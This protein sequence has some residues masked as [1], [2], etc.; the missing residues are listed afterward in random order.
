MAVSGF[1]VACQV[2]QLICRQ[3]VGICGKITSIKRS[4]HIRP[5]VWLTWVQQ[6]WLFNSYFTIAAHSNETST[7]AICMQN[8]S[9][10]AQSTS[11][12]MHNIALLS[13]RISFCKKE[14]Q[15]NQL[16]SRR[17]HICMCRP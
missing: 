5:P 10:A 14:P 6:K 8:T 7:M 12:R 2:S 9:N 16:S 17:R 11:F 15:Y 13:Q 1:A 3:V 4:G